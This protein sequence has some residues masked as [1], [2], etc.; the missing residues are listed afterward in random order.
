MRFH[1]LIFKMFFLLSLLPF[2]VSEKVQDRFGLRI[3]QQVEDSIFSGGNAVAEVDS[4][5]FS[6][7]SGLVVSR[8]HQ[9]VIYTHNDRGGKAEVYLLDSLGSYLGRIKLKGAGNRDWEDLAMGPGPE[10]G[11]TYIYVGEIGD[12]LGKYEELHIFRFPEPEHLE[13][14]MVVEPEK[15]TLRYPDGPKDSE[16]LL[17]D[18]WNGDVY[19]LTKRDSSNVLYRAPADR[20]GAGTVELEKVME[21]P[22]TMATGGDI[23][24]DGKQILI[25]NY[26][27]VYYWTREE[28]QTLEEAFANKPVQL[29]YKPEPQGEAIGFSA[30]GNSYFTLSEKRFRVEPVLYRYDKKTD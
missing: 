4:E 14:Q 17:V 2:L 10:E 21:L 20:L 6:E 23:S 19:L 26:W 13:E 29:P 15:F 28:G 8:S 30:N 24:A 11:K 3:N 7:V 22:I 16:T 27:V 12:N 5:I 25:K 1:D 9:G 18:P